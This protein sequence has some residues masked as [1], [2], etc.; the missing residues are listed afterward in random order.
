MKR[1]QTR[2][3][4]EDD[5]E[6][7]ITRS[8]LKRLSR[9]RQFEYMRHWFA[10]RY[11]DPA[12]E[13]P[14]NSEEGGYL[15]IWGGPYDAS[16]ELQEEFGDIIPYKRI[17]AVVADVEAD[18][19]RDWAPGT[20]HPDQQQRQD[21]WEADYEER[22]PEKSLSN[23]IRLL[24]SGTVTRFGTG[25]DRAQRQAIIARLDQLDVALAALKPAHGGLGHNNPPDDGSF[26][27]GE[28]EKAKFASA[29]IRR[30]LAKDEP[31]AITVAKAA[32]RL[33][34]ALGWFLKK[35][36]TAIEAFA[37]AVGDT[38]GKAVIAVSGVYV[39]TELVP[40]IAQNVAEFVVSTTNWLQLVTLSN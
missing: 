16:Q 13:T 14:Y 10:E 40:G 12:Q 22:E 7:G 6:T 37:K 36:D 23:L 19:I 5:F 20:R 31:D 4:T 18:G 30:E 39:T 25:S 34:R 28:I 32:S 35:A 24:E 27:S 1:S 26:P 15:F 29:D 11:E 8:Q 33:E 3:Y 21:E 38:T 17:E 9:Q 2:Y